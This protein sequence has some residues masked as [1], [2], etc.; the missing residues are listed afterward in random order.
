MTL[1][2]NE[3]PLDYEVRQYEPLTEE[4]LKQGGYEM[5]QGL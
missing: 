4:E 5:G 3:H 2:Y 1:E